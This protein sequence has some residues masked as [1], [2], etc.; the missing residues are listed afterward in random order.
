MSCDGLFSV[1]ENEVREWLRDCYGISEVAQRAPILTH[2]VLARI[3]C[4]AEAPSM[5]T[6]W[7]R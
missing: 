7:L 3:L 2:E 1:S 5:F 4:F 6:D